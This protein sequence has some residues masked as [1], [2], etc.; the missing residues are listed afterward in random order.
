MNSHPCG[1]KKVVFSIVMKSH[2]SVSRRCVLVGGGEVG[3]GGVE[4]F[5]SDK[6]VKMA[7][8]GVFLT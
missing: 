8:F 7:C 6:T 4:V 2:G 1:S 5:C 3:E